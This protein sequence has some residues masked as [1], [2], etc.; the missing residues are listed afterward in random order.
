V[1][2]KTFQGRTLEEVLPQIREELGPNAVVVGQRQKV[3]GGVAGFFGTKVVEVTAADQ[4]PGDDLL[5]ELEDQLMGGDERPGDREEPRSEDERELAERFAGAMR[6][7][8]VGGLDVTDEWDPSSDAELAQEYGR[9]LEHAAAAG[10]QELDV[11]A[12][13]ATTAVQVVPTE[14]IDQARRLVEQTHERVQQ[15]T[16]RVEQAAATGTYAPPRALPRTDAAEVRTF[17]AT[18]ESDPAGG[19]V[20]QAIPSPQAAASTVDHAL[21]TDLAMPRS[22]DTSLADALGAAIDG[23]DLAE[24]AALRSA[25]HA[26]RRDADAGSS[27][28]RARAVVRQLDLE[29]QPIVDRMLAVGVDRDVVDTIVDAAVRHRLPFGGEQDVRAVIRSVVE[30]TI[31]VR[32]GFPLL[33]RSHRAA[34]VGPAHAG[35]TSVVAQ[36][37]SRY[38]ATG[39]KVGI[40]SIV[41]ARPGVPVMA[42]RAY[43][44]LDAAVRYA[45]DPSQALDAM[46]AFEDRDVVLVDTPGSTYL[47]Q[48]AF[49][50]VQSCLLAIG[51]DDVHVV[52]P[53]ATSALEARSVVD[54]FRPLGANRLVVGRVDESRHIGQILN[55][56]FRLGLP[57]TYLSEGPIASG[58]L[59]A[60]CARDIADRILR[61]PAD[62]RTSD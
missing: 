37:A 22:T 7:G 39:M 27:R 13:A 33:D 29:V 50:R 49:A 55:F 41:V 2:I 5:V 35:R 38:A 24:I 36:V 1:R 9:V 59:R 31:E 16:S 46:E 51:I 52:L 20:P 60:A 57:M 21:R 53:L 3:Q 12:A 15:S 8:R 25:V 62:S 43:D 48:D 54:T 30:E 18:V 23:I 32:S 28:E 14:P 44:E 17:A 61:D 10:F 42:E 26:T 11:P 58:A 6:M 34:F 4:M 19:F 56:G 45:G 47:D 40:L